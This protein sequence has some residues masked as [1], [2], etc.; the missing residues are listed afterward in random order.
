LTILIVKNISTDFKII[1]G[2]TI[3]VELIKFLIT[4]KTR[5]WNHIWKKLL[6]FSL[7]NS[8]YFKLTKDENYIKFGFEEYNKL[9]GEIWKKNKNH[10]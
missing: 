5:I 3:V 1:A 6:Q 10:S 8:N 7:R 4:S 9:D 2:A